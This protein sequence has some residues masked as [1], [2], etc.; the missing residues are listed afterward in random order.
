MIKRIPLVKQVNFIKVNVI[1]RKIVEQIKKVRFDEIIEVI[2]AT[3]SRVVVKVKNGVG[4][5][6]RLDYIASI[7]EAS[8]PW[9]NDF[10]YVEANKV[11]IEQFDTLPQLFER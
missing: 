2:G 7:M 8:K 9:S 3:Q 4:Q 1:D 5:I 10:G 6:H 11:A